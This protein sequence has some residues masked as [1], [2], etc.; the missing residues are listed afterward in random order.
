MDISSRR[1]CSIIGG[2]YNPLCYNNDFSFAVVWQIGI[3][4]SA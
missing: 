1:F 3:F 2:T 4:I